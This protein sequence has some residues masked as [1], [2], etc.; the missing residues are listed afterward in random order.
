MIINIGGGAMLSSKYFPLC[1]RSLFARHESIR[2]E[3]GIPVLQNDKEFYTEVLCWYWK[4]RYFP[5]MNI[6]SK[7]IKNMIQWWLLGTDIS[8]FDLS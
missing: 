3:Q 5:S 7:Y 1:K 4:Q 2:N 6:I 8:E